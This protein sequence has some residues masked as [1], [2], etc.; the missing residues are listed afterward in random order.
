[1]LGICFIHPFLHVLAFFSGD[2]FDLKV[3]NLCVFTWIYHI[4]FRQVC[5]FSCFELSHNFKDIHFFSSWANLLAEGV[6]KIFA[7]EVRTTRLLVHIL[8]IYIWTSSHLSL[9][10]SK[11]PVFCTSSCTSYNLDTSLIQSW[12]NL[13]DELKD[14]MMLTS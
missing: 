7:K 12:C 9:V 13:L 11:S 6:D 5:Y 2:D 10:L 8:K 1:M 14:D 4:T 3:E